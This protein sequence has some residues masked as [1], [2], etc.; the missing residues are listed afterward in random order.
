M[1]K[2]A[3]DLRHSEEVGCFT[4]L[5]RKF[6]EH[7]L[8]CVVHGQSIVVVPPSGISECEPLANFDRA[9][10]LTADIK[11]ICQMVLIRV[12][13]LSHLELFPAFLYPAEFVVDSAER[14]MGRCIVRIKCKS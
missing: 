7:P 14:I 11:R 1:L 10:E 8:L 2:S 4:H 6:F 13:F 5:Y 3:R 9:I 12:E